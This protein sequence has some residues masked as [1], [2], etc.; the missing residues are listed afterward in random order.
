MYGLSTV[1]VSA[2]FSFRLILLLKVAVSDFLRYFESIDAVSAMGSFVEAIRPIES[3]PFCLQA[4]VENIRVSDS[5][6]MLFH[7]IPELSQ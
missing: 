4:F 7:F 2:V 3:A 1:P 6:A 5:E